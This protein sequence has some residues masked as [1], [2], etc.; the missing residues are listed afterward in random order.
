MPN[1]ILLKGDLGRRHEEYVAVGILSPGH[2]VKFDSN[3]K[4]L[5]ESVY[6]ASGLAVAKENALLGGTTATAYAVGDVVPVHHPLP[7]DELNIRLPAAAAAV[8]IGDKLV[9][10]GDGCLVKA[11]GGATLLYN[12][13]AASAAV[14]AIATEVAFDKSYTIPAN[15]LR[16]GDIINVKGQAIATATNSTDTLTIKL[17]IGGV[18][19]TMVMTSGAIDVANN[20]I[21]FF[22]MN[23]VVRTIG[24]SGTLVAYGFVSLGVAGTVT[25]KAVYLG[26]TAID[27]TVAQQIVPSATWSSNNAGN[28][29]RLDSLSVGLESPY[30]AAGGD[31][32]AMAIEAVDNSAGVAET[33][34]AVQVL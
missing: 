33:F 21:C 31:V 3:R 18:A 6:G 12:S 1:T 15:S 32:V 23:I 9:H 8:V 7:G 26:S 10:N 30:R 4:V 25:T 13:V 24:A 14:T 16:A 29:V 20:D 2:A 17:Y 22:E 19:G 11:L 5:K 27:T 28:S 34:L